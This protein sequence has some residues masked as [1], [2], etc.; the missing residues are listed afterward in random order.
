MKIV[1][2]GASTS[3]H[4]INKALATYTASLVEGGRWNSDG[5]GYK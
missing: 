4:S 1:A 5:A 3:R 2:F